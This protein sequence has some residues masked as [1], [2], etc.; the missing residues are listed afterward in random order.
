MKVNNIDHLLTSGKPGEVLYKLR[1]SREGWSLK[2]VKNDDISTQN[3]CQIE[4]RGFK[5]W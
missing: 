3:C 4:G 1:Q 5:I 2:S